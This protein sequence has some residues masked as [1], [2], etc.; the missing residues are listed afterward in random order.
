MLRILAAYVA[1]LAVACAWLWWGPDSAW[2]WLDT[3]VADL[4]ATLV[5]FGFSRW[6]GNSSFYDAYWSLAPPLLLLYWWAQAGAGADPVRVVLVTLV[7]VLWA[8]RLTANWV[9]TFP[10]M[11]HEDWRYPMLRE[12]AGRWEAVVDLFAIHVFPTLQVF[13]GSCRST[14]R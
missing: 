13:A 8:V 2:L 10:G 14:S 1:A 7:V 9:Y 5:V 3:L 11:H 4:L 6:Y 12:R